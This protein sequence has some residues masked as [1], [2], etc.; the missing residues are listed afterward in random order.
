M[1]TTASVTIVLVFMLFKIQYGSFQSLGC[2][3]KTHG[4]F[5]HMAKRKYFVDKSDLLKEILDDSTLGKT[6]IITCPKRFGKTTNM[7]MMRKFAEIEVNADGLPIAVDLENVTNTP[8]YEFF[9]QKYHFGG[10]N[11]ADDR[12]FM[13]K[14]F[15]RYPVIYMDFRA[16][17]HI[18]NHTDVIEICRLRIHQAFLQHA[19]LVN[20]KNLDYAYKKIIEAWTLLSQVSQL[21]QDLVVTGLKRLIE[22]LYI[23]FKQKVIVLIDEYDAMMQRY[24]L[25]RNIMNE[26]LK[27]IFS[28]FVDMLSNA[29]KK[30]GKLRVAV[31]TGVMSFSSAGMSENFPVE[32]HRFARDNEKNVWKYYGFTS[33]ELDRLFSI[34][35][36][37][38]NSTVR[39]QVQKYYDAYLVNNVQIY[40]PVSIFEFFTKE[41]IKPFWNMQTCGIISQFWKTLRIIDVRLKIFDL[42]ENQNITIENLEY[43]NFAHIELLKE[44]L[45]TN[46]LKADFTGQARKIFFNLLLDLGYFKITWQNRTFLNVTIPNLE[47]RDDIIGLLKNYK[48]QANSDE[49]LILQSK[50]FQHLQSLTADN[51]AYHL[52]EMTGALNKLSR[53]VMPFYPNFNSKKT[54][55]NDMLRSAFLFQGI[56]YY[57]EVSVKGHCGYV[58]LLVTNL[59]NVYIIIKTTYNGK[60]SEALNQTNQYVSVLDDPDYKRTQSCVLRMGINIS[61]DYKITVSAVLNVTNGTSYGPHHFPV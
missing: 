29:L 53:L 33:E 25:G 6:W 10:F 20:S 38:L 9:N 8:N 3:Q 19:Y 43:V 22:F 11:I 4:D 54:N 1:N 21:S 55:L 46:S 58:D 2:M 31:L 26:D 47:I 7:N 17:S 42:I 48:I 35:P 57:P 49:E 23:H 30:Q 56:R 37:K 40:T 14:H 52:Q 13:R 27:T 15:G 34:S 50:F 41:E 36:F 24:L 28:P 59:T 16:T 32:K 44:V 61:D 60:L 5:E 12:D 45:E 18:Q 39:D 51:H